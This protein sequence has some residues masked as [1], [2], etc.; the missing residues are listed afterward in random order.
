MLC[1]AICNASEIEPEAR[2]DFRLND[3]GDY[4]QSAWKNSPSLTVGRSG[5]P[6]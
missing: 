5:R 6:L 2:A 3:S 1:F 4:R